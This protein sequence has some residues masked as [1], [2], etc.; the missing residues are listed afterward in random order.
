MTG[1]AV[2]SLFLSILESFRPI[3]GLS[4]GDAWEI[5]SVAVLPTYYYICVVC[6]LCGSDGASVRVSIFYSPSI[7]VTSP[8][9]VSFSP[10]FYHCLESPLTSFLLVP[11][12][13]HGSHCTFPIYLTVSES[14][15]VAR[16]TRLEL[17]VT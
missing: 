6:D 5:W 14:A 1:V 11:F 7:L 3:L 4:V 13:S 16:Q 10:P 8:L 15:H 12:S 17:R 2:G 9:S